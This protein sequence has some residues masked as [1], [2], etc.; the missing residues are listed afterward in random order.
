MHYSIPVAHHDG[1][2][3]TQIGLSL[4]HTNTTV[5]LKLLKQQ[6][7]SKAKKYILLA[8]QILLVTYTWLPDAIASVAKC[9][10]LIDLTVQQSLTG[11]I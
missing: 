9:F 6:T 4:Q 7:D 1:I 3:C 8:N 5:N 2:G 10:V 11:Y